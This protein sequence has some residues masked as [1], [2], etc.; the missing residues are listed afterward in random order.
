MDYWKEGME[1]LTD[2]LDLN[3][4]SFHH[5]YPDT[6]TELIWV[7]TGGW[8]ENEEVLNQLLL[9]H[10]IFWNL[11]WQKSKKGGYYEFAR[12]IPPK[13]IYHEEYP[14]EELLK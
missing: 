5:E 4:G 6:E 9:K 10:E 12:K 3:Y 11:Y 1:F 8:S 13:S 2:N 7:T 14:I